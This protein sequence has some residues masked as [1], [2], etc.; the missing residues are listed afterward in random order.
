MKKKNI[1]PLILSSLAALAVAGI[2]TGAT[3]ALFTDKAETTINVQAGVVNMRTT[4]TMV[5]T[6]SAVGNSTGTEQDENGAKYNLVDQTMGSFLNGG[7]AS[8]SGGV[9]SVDKLTPG[10]GVKFKIE[11]HN[12][13]NVATKYR[14]V[15]QGDQ[16]D[17]SLLRGLTLGVKNETLGID[18]KYEGIYRVI[19]AWQELAVGQEIGTFAYDLYLPLTS[20]N[21]YQG[22]SGKL[23]IGIEVVQGNAVVS[24]EEAGAVEIKGITKGPELKELSGQSGY[25]VVDQDFIVTDASD[26][27]SFNSGISFLDLAGHTITSSAT[28]IATV[29][30]GARL[31]LVNTGE[32]GKFVSVPSASNS[33]AFQVDGGGTLILD[34]ADIERSADLGIFA[35]NGNVVL[36]SGSINGKGS[37]YSAVYARQNTEVILNDAAIN[38]FDLGVAFNADG[39][40]LTMN[41]GS[42]KDVGYGVGQWHNGDLVFNGGEIKAKNYAFFTNGGD[43]L[44]ANITVNG[45]TFESEETGVYAAGCKTFTMHGGSITGTDTAVSMRAGHF[46]MDGGTLK[47]TYSGEKL[48]MGNDSAGFG[49]ALTQHTT[50]QSLTA[51]ITGGTISAKGGILVENT[52]NNDIYLKDASTISSS[53]DGS[54]LLD[55]NGNPVAGE[56]YIKVSDVTFMGSAASVINVDQRYTVTLD[57]VTA[58]MLPSSLAANSGS[59]DVT[60]TLNDNYLY[61]IQG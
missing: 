8:F 9:L 51:N 21:E 34:G 18:K 40:N 46:E 49:L 10:D 7:T 4:A 53:D 17:I 35:S 28:A 60:L 39:G 52:E 24:D 6:Y 25:F 26:F 44:F 37:G 16:D 61:N 41:G 58:A 38:G 29:T 12:E 32:S 27:A 19:T 36:N 42:I 33:R 15:I 23:Q 47:S 22:L 31:T 13:S 2:G 45:G 20:G 48:V 56:F 1:R 55:E 14:L 43:S 30:N 5:S 54:A 57:A 11:T 50:K 59:A 3:F